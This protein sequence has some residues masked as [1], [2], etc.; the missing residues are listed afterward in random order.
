MSQNNPIKVSCDPETGLCEIPESSGAL[1]SSIEWN[2]DEEIIYVGDPMCSWCWGISPQL[3]ALQRYGN[4]NGIPFSLV[5]GGLR[6]GGGD[7]WNAE[8]KDFLKHHWEEVHTRSGQPFGYRLFN[9]EYF[10]YDT[11]PA[12]R[13]VV[14][15]RN[16]DPNKTLRFYELVQHSFYVKSN[17]PKQPTFY[18][19]ICEKLDIDFKAFATK[20]LSAEMKAATQQ[21]FKQ[22]RQWGVSGFPAVLYRK[23]DQLYY[24]ARGFSTYET[25]KETLENIKKDH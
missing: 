9:L 3:N 20:F 6:P 2:T 5:M 23:N 19:D 22:N 1:I 25:M 24:I 15:V 7:E 11:E 18:R 12:C 8:F 14:T 13:A 17:D 16:I 4:Q 10:D 21:D